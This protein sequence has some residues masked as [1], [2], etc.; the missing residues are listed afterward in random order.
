MYTIVPVPRPDKVIFC[1][2]LHDD[3]MERIKSNDPAVI[4][5]NYVAMMIGLKPEQGMAFERF[6]FLVAY[7][8]SQDEFEAKCKELGDAQKVLAY[9]GRNWKTEPGDYA[10]PVRVRISGDE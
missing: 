5:G 10:E 7:E 9:L 6:D 4:T 1:V 8:P 2:V 3:S